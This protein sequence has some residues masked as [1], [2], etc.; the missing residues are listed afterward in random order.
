MTDLVR[1]DP[2]ADLVGWAQAGS[3]ANQLAKAVCGT[4]F[5]PKH[6]QGKPDEATAAILY[7]AEAGLSPMQAL[8][9]IYVISGKPALY[10]RTMMAVVLA[11]GHEVWTEKLTD[12]EAVVCGRRAGSEHVERAEWTIAR[13]QQAGYATNQKYRTDPQAMLL[14]R[15][16]SDVCRRIAPDALLGMAHSVEELEDGTEAPAAGTVSRSKPAPKAEPP[17]RAVAPA[18]STGSRVAATDVDLP[19]LDDEPTPPEPAPADDEPIDAEIVD[20]PPPEP[21]PP[22]AEPRSDGVTDAQL[23]KLGALFRACDIDDRDMKLAFAI[24]HIGRD[25]ASSK[26]MSKA[27]A[28]K[29]IDSLTALEA[30]RRNV[31][32][33][34]P[35]PYQERGD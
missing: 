10:A 1:H 8:Q 29:V 35:L 23:R 13:A 19:P 27:E 30:A 24:D 31:P 14:A 4:S 12:R 9:G 18:I 22:P 3:A 34:D 25:I 16:Q 6:F 33:D 17:K 2:S 7:G 15:A 20:E 11:A 32:D 28:S 5:V 21:E 26:D